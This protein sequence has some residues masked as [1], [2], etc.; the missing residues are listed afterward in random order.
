QTTRRREKLTTGVMEA[1]PSP[2]GKTFAF[3]IRGDIWTVPIEKPK[4]V[5]GRNAELARRLTD[6]VGDD[7]DFSWSKDGKKLYFTSDRDFSTRLYELDLA[8]LKANAL[9][10]RNDDITGVR[11]SPDGAQIGFWAAGKEGGLH[12]LSIASGEARR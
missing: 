5:E 4:G 3:G 9:W 7:S 6:W 11:V 8:T 12:V 2:D 1:E 10:K